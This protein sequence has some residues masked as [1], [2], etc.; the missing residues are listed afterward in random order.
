[1]AETSDIQF[2]EGVWPK[3]NGSPFRTGRQRGIARVGG[4]FAVSPFATFKMK[5]P[6]GAVVAR[7]CPPR[8][9]YEILSFEAKGHLRDRR[10]SRVLVREYG[11]GLERVPHRS[12]TPAAK[13][14]LQRRGA[15]TMLS[16]WPDFRQLGRIGCQPAD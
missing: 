14:E 7:D 6:T 4:A 11:S 12:R 13:N 3:C 1:M 16:N 15:S 8:T 9:K 2:L 5:T 10:R